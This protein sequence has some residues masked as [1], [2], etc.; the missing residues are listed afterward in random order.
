MKSSLKFTAI[1]LLL[2]GVLH[3]QNLNAATT[4]PVS[5]DMLDELSNP[6]GRFSSQTE[7]PKEFVSCIEKLVER[8]SNNQDFVDAL[9]AAVISSFLPLKF[10]ED[11]RVL[12]KS[13]LKN[14]MRYCEG[15]KTGRISGDTV[16]SGL[17]EELGAFSAQLETKEDT[18]KRQKNSLQELQGAYEFLQRQIVAEKEMRSQLEAQLPA[19]LAELEKRTDEVSSLQDDVNELRDCVVELQQVAQSPEVLAFSLPKKDSVL[20]SAEELQSVTALSDAIEISSE[21]LN[22]PQE[23]VTT[24][25]AIRGVLESSEDLEAELGGLDGR[26]ADLQVA[27]I[28]NRSP[29]NLAKAAFFVDAISHIRGISREIG[30]YLKA[31]KTLEG[32]MVQEEET[33][34]AP[35]SLITAFF[36]RVPEPQKVKKYSEVQILMRKE[37][38]KRKDLG[39]VFFD[40]LFGLESTQS[41]VLGTNGLIKNIADKPY[42]TMIN[43]DSTTATGELTF[44]GGLKKLA[45]DLG[46]NM[47]EA[48]KL[49]A[50]TFSSRALEKL[51]GSP[52]AVSAAVPLDDA[53]YDDSTH[54]DW[55]RHTDVPQTNGTTTVGNSIAVAPTVRDAAAP[56]SDT[57]ISE[58]D[59]FDSTTKLTNAEDTTV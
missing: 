47:L 9:K 23:M 49:T 13:P 2:G 21:K 27:A 28:R 20:L 18:L 58:L 15:V 30:G 12:A 42:S 56:I 44:M 51:F 3:V 10:Y 55:G 33:V 35:V 4:A 7:G 32:G 53:L 14:V 43:P 59:G 6:S 54:S 34:V 24:L 45:I 8:Y 16:I 5:L 57:Q 39:F 17:R 40:Y 46:M 11:A 48:K 26:L 50:S 38:G 36:S 22:L 31:I 1:A 41:I 29:E 25:S 19:T 52:V 37:L